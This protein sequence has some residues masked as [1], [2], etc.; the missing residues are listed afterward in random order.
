[1]EGGPLVCCIIP[2]CEDFLVTE[3][4]ERYLETLREMERNEV[5]QND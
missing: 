5:L 2:D 4:P 1:M 3:Q